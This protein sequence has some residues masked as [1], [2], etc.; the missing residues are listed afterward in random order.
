MNRICRGLFISKHFQ[1]PLKSHKSLTISQQPTQRPLSLLCTSKNSLLG[2]SWPE[3]LAFCVKTLGHYFQ[4]DAPVYKWE[5]VPLLIGSVLTYLLLAKECVRTWTVSQRVCWKESL[6]FSACGRILISVAQEQAEAGLK[7]FKK[8]KKPK[9]P[10][11]LFSFQVIQKSPT[12][13]FKQKESS[14][15]N[16]EAPLI[17]WEAHFCTME[18]CTRKTEADPASFIINKSLGCVW[19][20]KFS[21]F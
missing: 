10:L 18:D 17:F 12:G 15:I 21:T 7:D 5:E 6:W 16:V 20:N 14:I 4:A 8:T 9:K 2:C 11:S 1:E 19:V 13:P 3:I